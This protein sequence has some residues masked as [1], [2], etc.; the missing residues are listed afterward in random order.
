MK[1][2]IRIFIVI[3]I[4]LFFLLVILGLIASFFSPII[5]LTDYSCEQ[6]YTSLVRGGEPL[7]A[8]N[9]GFGFHF[10]QSYYGKEDILLSYDLR[11]AENGRR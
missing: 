8:R 11:C 5:P 7:L 3:M 2:I 4:I 6:M 9:N 10:F 1:K